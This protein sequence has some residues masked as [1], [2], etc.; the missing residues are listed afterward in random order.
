MGE[1]YN[2]RYIACE[3]CDRVVRPETYRQWHF[4][5][6]GNGFKSL[7]LDKH[8]IDKLKGK[9]RDDAYNSDFLFEVN[10]NWMLQG[11][12]GKILFGSSCW[13]PA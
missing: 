2:E 7:K 12:K 5:H 1:G 3:G 4:R 13:I 8:V 10:E 9:L 6:M 11:W